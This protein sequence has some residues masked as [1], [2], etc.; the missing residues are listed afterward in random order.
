MTFDQ[1][2]LLSDPFYVNVNQMLLGYELEGGKLF[3]EFIRGVFV[4]RVGRLLPYYWVEYTNGINVLVWY[5]VLDKNMQV[6]GIFNGV[7][8]NFIDA[9]IIETKPVSGTTQNQPSSVLQNTNS[10]VISASKN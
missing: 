4:K 2:T 10:N 6:L 3:R 9:K 1:A 5:D 7:D 8:L